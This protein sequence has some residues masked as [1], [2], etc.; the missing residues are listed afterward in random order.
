[1]AELLMPDGSKVDLTEPSEELKGLAVLA[2]NQG[3]I[4]AVLLQMS[5]QLEVL[6]RLACGADSKNSWKVKFTEADGIRRAEQ[7]MA[8]LEAQAAS[9]KDVDDVGVRD[10]GQELHQGDPYDDA[11]ERER[12]AGD[13]E[14]GDDVA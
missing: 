9:G 12:R 7:R 8:A 11:V 14:K 4:H 13:V 10:E 5:Q 1:M 3:A 2:Q 6:I